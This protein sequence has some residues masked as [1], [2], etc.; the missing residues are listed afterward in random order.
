MAEYRG[1]D[2]LDYFVLIVKWKRVLL[3][4]FL[5]TVSAAYLLIYFLLP[6]QYDSMATIVA[7]ED[8]NLNPISSITKSMGNLPFASLGLGQF[9]ASEKYDLFN[10]IILSRTNLEKVIRKFDL[11]EDYGSESLEKSVKALKANINLDVTTEMAYEIEV[12]ASSPEKSVEMTNF[13]L[14]EVNSSVIDLNVRKSKENRE[15]LER[16]YKEISA[17]LAAAED[18]LMLF[19]KKSGILEAENQIKATVELF[20]NLESEVALKEIEL[21]VLE[22]IYGKNASQTL[23]ARIN[24]EE[25]RNELNMLSKT[26]KKESAIVP[27]STLPKN[28]MQYFRYFR[29]VE[30]NQAMLEFII[31][32]YEQARFEEVKDVPVIQVIDYP[33]LPEKKAYPPRT[34]YALLISIFVVFF[35]SIILLFKENLENSQNPKLKFIKKE[36]FKF[37]KN[38]K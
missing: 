30:I 1:F 38:K 16:R 17:N 28:A 4:Q 21:A 33:S 8:Q 27:L 36:L 34:I 2:L 37:S 22:K 32:L 3:V 12:R 18:S 14:D 10:T 23:N 29:D 35:T 20:A 19:Q 6:P 25:F 7:V 15:F 9:S 11:M 5:V 24:F 31:P 26:G 13:L